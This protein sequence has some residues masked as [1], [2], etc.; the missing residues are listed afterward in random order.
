MISRPMLAAR[1]RT[2]DDLWFPVLGT[3]KF[4]GIRCLKFAGHA[5]SRA[6]KPIR[7]LEVQKQLQ[8]LPDGLDG[9]LMSL[10]SF[11]DTTSA[12]MSYAG[13]PDFEYHVFDYFGAGLTVPYYRRMEQLV[14]LSLPS[15]VRIVAGIT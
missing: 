13:K 11:Q 9:E 3:P 8:G 7:N 1:A 15:F 12:V 14:A 6:F 5:Y 10:G 2:Y 4:D